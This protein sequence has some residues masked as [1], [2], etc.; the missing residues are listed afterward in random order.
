MTELFKIKLFPGKLRLPLS[1]LREGVNFYDDC[2]VIKKGQD[3]HVFSSQCTHLGCRINHTDGADKLICPCH[4]SRFDFEGHPIK[5]PAFKPLQKLTYT[6]DDK[7][8]IE[9]ELI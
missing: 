5:G 2:I 7:G 9:I 3:I 1:Q 4:G 8:N 6:K